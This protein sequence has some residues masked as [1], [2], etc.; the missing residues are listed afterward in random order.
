MTKPYALHPPLVKDRS[1]IAKRVLFATTVVFV[2]L[3]AP[4]SANAE[5]V[6]VN[7]EGQG[8]SR[9]EAVAAA[10][11]S[12]VE[13]VSGVKIEGSSSLH[14]ELSS[15]STA[16]SKSVELNELQQMAVKRQ[17]GGIVKNYDVVG[18]DPEGDGFVARLNVS[19]ERYTPPGLPTEDR[20]RIVVA[21]PGNLSSLA[22][23][24][25]AVLRDALDSYLVQTRR[26]AVLDREN[27]AAYHSEMEMLKSPDV[28]VSETARIGQV[29]GTD[30]V[31]LTKV[32]QLES[33]TRDAVLPITGQRVTRQS[34]RS[35][36]EFSIVEIATRQVKWAGQLTGETTGD[37]DAALR[38]LASQIG[39]KIVSDIYP[40]RVVN[41]LGPNSV[42]LNQGADT[43]KV[44]QTYSANV[45]GNMAFDPYTKEP[46]GRVETPV[47][48]VRISRVDPKLSY[49]D[50]TSG[51]LPGGDAEIILRASTPE[52]EQ[53]LE[54]SAGT[55]NTGTRPRW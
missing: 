54:P 25:V 1:S 44:G 41:V 29:I 42:V 17:T 18:V 13:Q 22:P 36:A 53:R 27:D 5:T 39:E 40:L 45:L 12:A 26:F 16:E 46:L 43:I 7:A 49:G 31:L 32:R 28:A 30:Y 2:A 15:S 37:R 14:Q 11:V 10:L 23:S 20:R 50:L 24:E 52:H 33:T 9:R 6:R 3:S 34:T 38:T 21:Q 55:T 35:T 19:I 51:A 48:T 8:K 4:Y 47:G